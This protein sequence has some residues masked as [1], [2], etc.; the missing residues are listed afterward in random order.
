MARPQVF[1]CLPTAQFSPPIDLV[2]NLNNFPFIP[3][4][5]CTHLKLQLESQHTSDNLN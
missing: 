1:L 3:P 5:H 4:L 2:G